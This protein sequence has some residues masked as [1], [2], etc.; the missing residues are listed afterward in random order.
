MAINK[1]L[2]QLTLNTIKANPKHWDQGKWHCGTTHCFAGFAY[3][4]HMG[5]PLTT[6][7]HD[8]GV[9]ILCQT[10]NIVKNLLGL[11][12]DQ[13]NKLFLCDNTL[14]DLEHYVNVLLNTDLPLSSMEEVRPDIQAASKENC[15]AIRVDS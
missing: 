7:H 8:L 11:T 9:D 15:M 5:L 12:F 6:T 14:E 13:A 1:E 10:R 2:L 3:L 4:L